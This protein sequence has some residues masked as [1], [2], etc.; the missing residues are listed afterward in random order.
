V[1]DFL[2][3]LGSPRCREPANELTLICP[4]HERERHLG[5]LRR[6]ASP[7]TRALS[8]AL[9]WLIPGRDRVPGRPVHRTADR[10]AGA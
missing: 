5:E 8:Y 4:G 10:E 3:C 1:N 2:Q 6:S 9:A 7:S